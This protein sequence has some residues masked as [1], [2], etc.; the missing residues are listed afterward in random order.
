[1]KRLLIIALVFATALVT[2]QEG[3]NRQNKE[4]GERMERYQD[5]SPEEIATLQT[6][7]LT[8]HLDLTKSQQK[9]IQ[10]LNIENAKEKKAKMEARKSQKEGG[11]LQKPSKEEHYKMMNER[12]DKQIAMK[13]KMKN[14]LNEDQFVKWEQMQQDMKNKMIAK[15]KSQKKGLYKSQKNK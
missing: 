4:R 3:D 1:M 15:N 7:K 9:D 8:L 10:K 2:A 5:Y 14:I 13:N 12:L 11:E 6:K